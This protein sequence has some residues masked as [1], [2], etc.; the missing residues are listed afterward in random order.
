MQYDKNWLI[1]YRAQGFEGMQISFD[2]GVREINTINHG[3]S[4]AQQG[5][6][7]SDSEGNLLFYTEGC[8]VY[9]ASFNL[10]ENGDSLNFGDIY[11][12][13]CVSALGGYPAGP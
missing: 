1:G 11:S 5:L 8:Q 12:S 2:A 9:D 13:Y 10:M 7:M 6:T 4:M 3:L